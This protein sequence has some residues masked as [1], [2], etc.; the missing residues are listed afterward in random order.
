[1]NDGLLYVPGNSH[2]YLFSPFCFF[3]HQRLDNLH[4]K[5]FSLPLRRFQQRRI[6]AHR[7]VQVDALRLQVVSAAHYG[8]G[9]GNIE[10][11]ISQIG[12]RVSQHHSA[13]DIQRRIM[14][15]SFPFFF[16]FPAGLQL[17][18]SVG[19]APARSIKSTFFVFS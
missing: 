4:Q 19:Y 7:A 6:E 13:L 8:G 14:Q 2:L 9:A 17:C 18:P 15:L 10:G 11:D 16:L 3:L 1:M 5:R 12:N